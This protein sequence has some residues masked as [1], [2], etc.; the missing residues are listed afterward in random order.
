[1]CVCVWWILYDVAARAAPLYPEIN[2]DLASG[3]V[4][5]RQQARAP[6]QQHGSFD[7]LASGRVDV[8]Q[9]TQAPPQQ[10][11]VCHACDGAFVGDTRVLI[12]TAALVFGRIHRHS[13]AMLKRHS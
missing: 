10:Q 11:Q 1:V 8:H 3:R 9:H 2:D 12:S 5:V 6:G 4:D 7:D 13:L